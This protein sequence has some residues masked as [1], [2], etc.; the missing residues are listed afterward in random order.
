[1]MR[2]RAFQNNP[3]LN[4]RTEPSIHHSITQHQ[5]QFEIFWYMHMLF[6]IF[7]IAMVR[8]VL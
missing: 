2:L 3:A 6:P 8:S 5:G 7:F 1:M 4:K